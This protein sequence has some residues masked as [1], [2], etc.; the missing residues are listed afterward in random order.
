MIALNFQ[1]SMTKMDLFYLN[2]ILLVANLALLLF[3]L[4]NKAPKVEFFGDGIRI[5]NKKG[6]TVIEYDKPLRK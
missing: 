3:Q 4:L 5:K 2:L 1:N 6:E